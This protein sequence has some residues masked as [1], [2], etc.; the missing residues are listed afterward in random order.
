MD[1]LKVPKQDFYIKHLS[2]H[3]QYTYSQNWISW[4][5]KVAKFKAIR[6]TQIVK[7]YKDKNAKLL[8]LG[9]GIGLTLS[10]LAQEFHRS[11]GCDIDKEALIATEKILKKVGVKI[12][13]L[14]YD[15]KKLPFKDNEFDVV[16]CIE[17][18]EHV[19]N[20]EHFLKE[21]SRV[22]KKDGILHI[23]TANK[24]WPY[25][26]HFK[27]LFLSYLPENLANAYVKFSGKGKSYHGIKLPSYGRFKKMIGKYFKIED[28]TLEIIENY[29]KYN[30][31]KERGRKV[32]I[33]GE[34]L[35]LLRNFDIGILSPMI[36]LIRRLLLR[37]SLGW[38]FIAQPKK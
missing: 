24:W 34:C 8:D 27:L 11:V 32:K 18:I 19:E 6:T 25:E 30:F 29:H 9:C 21:I 5:S 7:L 2:E 38:L 15:G 10:I 13:L 22:L 3:N 35:R 1:N 4:Y 33:V 14:F 37:V 12:P 31:D 16:T 26:P 28:L 36:L 20:P 23:T 17:V